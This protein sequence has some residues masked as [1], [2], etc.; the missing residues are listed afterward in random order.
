MPSLLNLA[1]LS[2]NSRKVFLH[3]YSYAFWKLSP[4]DKNIMCRLDSSSAGKVVHE[5]LH[6]G[7][8]HLC[9]GKALSIQNTAVSHLAYLFLGCGMYFILVCQ[10]L[11]SLS[12]T[13]NCRG[14]K[15]SI[16]I[17][18]CLISSGIH[19][20]LAHCS[21]SF[22]QICPNMPWYWLFSFFNHL[23]SCWLRGSLI[24]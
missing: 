19:L 22:L 7:I 16:T 21:S 24:L 11:W 6:Q 17:S 18:T 3:S 8:C 5:N 14:Q 2:L 15:L 13:M 4:L 20:S 10:S 12:N 1:I 9:H 23:Q